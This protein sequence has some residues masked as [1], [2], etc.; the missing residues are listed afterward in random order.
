MQGGLLPPGVEAGAAGNLAGHGHQASDGAP[1]QGAEVGR[2]VVEADGDA[3]LAEPSLAEGA[4][5]RPVARRAEEAGVVAVQGGLE[6]E[7]DFP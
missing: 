4:G 6:R 3:A 2:I 7:L 5:H 1:L